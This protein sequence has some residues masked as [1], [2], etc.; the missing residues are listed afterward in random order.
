MAVLK[1]K[2]SPSQRISDNM[3]YHDLI[4]KQLAEDADGGATTS[5]SVATVVS[6]LGSSPSNELKKKKKKDKIAVIRRN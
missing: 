6:A 1:H 5:A 2:Q 4:K 3:R